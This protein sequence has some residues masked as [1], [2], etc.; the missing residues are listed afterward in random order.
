M[1]KATKLTQKKEAKRLR[2]TTF[3]IG[4]A[5][6]YWRAI[7]KVCNIKSYDRV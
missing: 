7:E 6:S 4:R 1:N 3:T 2:V 5:I